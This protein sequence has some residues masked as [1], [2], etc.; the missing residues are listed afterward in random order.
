MAKQFLIR[1]P[2]EEQ[3]SFLKMVLG[4]LDTHMQENEAGSLPISKWG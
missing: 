2:M 1:V 3:Q 4:I